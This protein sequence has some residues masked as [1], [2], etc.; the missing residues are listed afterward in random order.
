MQ[1]SDLI[2]M[3]APVNVHPERCIRCY[4]PRANCARCV[5]FCPN[6]S[7]HIDGMN[8]S[9]DTCDGCGRCIQACS[10]DVFEMDFMDVF[11][12]PKKNPLIICCRKNNFPDLPVFAAG[13]LQQ[14]TWLQLA[15]LVRHFGDI[16]LYADEKNCA[17]C[18]FDWFPEGQL[19]LMRRYGLGTYADKIKIIR[20]PDVM[21][22]CLEEHY[23]DLNTRREYMKKQFSHAK[24]AA[25]KYTR[26]SLEGYLDAFRE[27]VKPKDV[28]TFEKRQSQALL[29]HELYVEA[30][31]DPAQ[32]IPLEMLTSTRCRFCRACETL[33][34]WQAIAIVEEAGQAV[35]AYHD[36]LCARCGLC[37]DICPE[38]GLYWD[39][40]LTVQDIANPHWRILKKAEEAVCERCGERFYPTEEGQTLCAICRNKH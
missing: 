20:E 5:Q 34:P 8:I 21:R 32:E 33:C 37:L 15:I 19:L 17:S 3:A 4:S 10:Y 39:H 24:H 31:S 1:I 40:G 14:F 11:K 13:C 25:E 9:V 6:G 7:I 26:Q 29:L 12:M 2:A 22:S 38:Q 36:V 23:T 16:V 35:L 28:S 27:T 30:D 18:D